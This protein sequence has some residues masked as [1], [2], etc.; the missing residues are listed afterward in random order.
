MRF[1]LRVIIIAVVAVAALVVLL[2]LLPGRDKSPPTVLERHTVGP[3]TIEQTVQ[4]TG[5]LECATAAAIVSKVK[6]KL[7]EPLVK[8]GDQV[9]E[10]KLLIRITNDEIVTAVNLKKANI[11]QLEE[12]LEDMRKAPEDR[13]DVKKAKAAWDRARTEYQRKQKQLDDEEAKDPPT[14]SKRALEELREDVAFAKQDAELAKDAYEEA[15]KAVSEADV[16]EAEE[17]VAQAKAE[18]KDLEEQADG[19]EVRSPIKG[20]VLKVMIEAETLAVDPDKEYAKDTP[21]FVVA[22]LDSIFVRGHIYQS[23]GEKLDRERMEAG[24]YK[25]KVD[26]ASLGRRLGGELSYLSRMLVESSSGVRQFEVKITFGTPPKDVTD[27]LQ[28]SFEIVVNR[29]ENVLVVPVRFV[30]LD[31]RRAFVQ[32]L[33][34]G[35]PVR[36]EVRIGGFDINNYQILGGLSEGDV[37]QCEPTSK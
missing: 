16:Q 8:E 1:A 25:A 2:R 22:D 18:L 15:K 19:R 27:G 10:G 4:G 23:D 34:G 5:V 17:T 3:G 35:K 14:L 12:D 36:T 26:L 33:R 9:A 11:A 24:D 37:V 31:G 29:V 6:G 32:K 21:L 30:E 20:T 28:V 7:A 13:T